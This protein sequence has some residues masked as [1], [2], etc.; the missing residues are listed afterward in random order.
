[1]NAPQRE[2]LRTATEEG[3]WIDYIRGEREAK[4]DVSSGD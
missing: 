1:M 2:V 4:S 3:N